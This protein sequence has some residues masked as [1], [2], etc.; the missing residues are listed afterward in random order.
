M[1]RSQANPPTPE[2]I[3]RW[4]QLSLHGGWPITDT[5]MRHLRSLKS[6]KHLDLRETQITDKGPMQLTAL[7]D[8]EEVIVSGTGVTNTRVCGIPKGHG[9]Q[10]RLRVF[11]RVAPGTAECP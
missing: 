10:H 1:Y 11:W 5:G 6:L 9:R 4:Y 7:E 2:P 3:D 8:L